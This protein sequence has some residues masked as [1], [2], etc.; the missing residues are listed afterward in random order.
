M[1]DN[2]NLHPIWMRHFGI[3]QKVT[4]PA[5]PGAIPAQTL[6]PVK[7]LTS[8]RDGW[9]P[10]SPYRPGYGGPVAVRKRLGPY[11]WATTTVLPGDLRYPYPDHIDSSRT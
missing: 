7:L 2:P 3:Q 1:I 10:T 4:L 11:T 6:S 8:E 9:V 5:S